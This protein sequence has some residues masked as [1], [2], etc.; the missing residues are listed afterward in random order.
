MASALAI[1]L[2]AITLIFLAESWLSFRLPF[3]DGAIIGDAVNLATLPNGGR[4]AILT[5]MV[6][7]L[8]G[9]AALALGWDT[10]RAAA[11]YEPGAW[12]SGSTTIWL[13]LNVTFPSAFRVEIFLHSTPSATAIASMLVLALVVAAALVR[14]PSTPT[15]TVPDHPDL[16]ACGVR[17]RHPAARDHAGPGGLPIGRCRTRPPTTRLGSLRSWYRA[18]PSSA[19]WCSLFGTQPCSNAAAAWQHDFRQRLT[20]SRTSSA[21]PGSR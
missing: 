8:G 17:H 2:L 11:V 14:P 19:W 20:R 15:R 4:P 13:L 16:A 10:R 12:I 5:L 1:G 18:A 21:V 7:I 3:L 9:T 6:A